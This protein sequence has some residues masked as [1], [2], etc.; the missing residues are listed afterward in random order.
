MKKL[1]TEKMV[2]EAGKAGQTLRIPRGTLLT[3]S[4]K[5]RIKELGLTVII[6]DGKANAPPRPVSKKIALGCD[7][8]GY[9]MKQ[10]VKKLLTEMGEV[11]IDV[12]THSTESVDYP[13][14]AL[15]VAELV[16]TGECSKGIMIDGAGIGSCMVAN[17]VPGV[18]A[19]LCYDVSTAVNSREHNDANVLTLGG[20]L[21]G[22]QVAEHIIKAWLKT[23][24]AGG[25]HQKRIDKIEAADK[26]HR[27]G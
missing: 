8:G 11:F 16:Q 6:E 19:A 1:L 27:K 17:K 7:H 26:K 2:T 13:D 24:F 20:R 3:P 5:D 4:A 9:V 22:E 25:R 10:F 15:K 12:G 21:I 23:E 14:Y 18:R